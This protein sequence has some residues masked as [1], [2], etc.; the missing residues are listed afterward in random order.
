M[1]ASEDW[2][3]NHAQPVKPLVAMD[4]RGILVT[5]AWGE[6]VQVLGTRG[7]A[8]NPAVVE[9]ERFDFGES[10]VSVLNP[11]IV[12]VTESAPPSTTASRRPPTQER[13]SF[14]GPCDPVV[15]GHI[16]S[17]PASVGVVAQVEATG[18]SLV[19]MDTRG[20]DRDPG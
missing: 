2:R 14:L 1:N 5:K 17:Q 19:G 15:G 10:W 12:S 13:Q 8:L 20:G 4:V 3:A 18:H 16:G 6:E 7:L 9:S 11:W